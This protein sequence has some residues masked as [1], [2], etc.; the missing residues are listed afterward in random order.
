MLNEQAQ[1]EI[2][3]AIG[4]HGAWKHRLR[5]AAMNKETN[6]PV[7]DI[8]RDDKCRFGKWLAT[9]P[10]DV[11]NAHHLKKIKQLHSEFHTIAG[12]IARQIAAG[13][14]AGAMTALNAS[15]FTGKS[16]DLTLA[17]NEW[18]RSK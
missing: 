1:I 4:A 13:D 9:V 12:G 17:L 7:H 2:K 3:E 11:T 15:D 16:R 8:C 10:Q 5:T 18:K 14:S 6:L